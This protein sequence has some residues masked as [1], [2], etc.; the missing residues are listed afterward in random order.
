MS[1]PKH[2]APHP[3]LYIGPKQLE[4]LKR[5][6]EFPFLD[7]AASELIR[8]ADE[9]APNSKFE[10]VRNTHN[11]HLIRARHMQKRMVTLLAA[12]TRTGEETY[13]SAA[14]EHLDEMANWDYWSWIAHRNGEDAPDAI[15]D[16]SYGENS[17]TIAIAYDWLHDSLSDAE[18]RRIVDA[19]R[20]RPLLSGVKHCHPDGAWWFGKRD[21]NWNAV[22][23]GG[24]GMLCLAM[25][26]DA[27]EAFETLK[28]CEESV[29]AFMSYLD[30]TQGGWPE[31]IGYW[32]Y[33]MRYA[34]MFLL[35]H[36]A[37]T[38]EPNP[39]LELDGARRTLEFPLDF[40]PRGQACS[41]GDVNRW[42]PLPF[43]RA[44]AERLENH[45]V[46]AAID[47]RLKD[48]STI[49]GEQR[50]SNAAEW[51][52]LHP[53]RRSEQPRESNRHSIRKYYEGVNWGILADDEIEPNRYLALRSGS[54]AV[55]HGHRDLLSFH[56][57]IDGERL[58]TNASP[59]E[60]L[61]STF[62]PRR[63]ELFEMSPFG[64]NTL[65]INGV[66]IEVGSAVDHTDL[67]DADGAVGFRLD[68]TTAMG[69][70]RGKEPAALFCG[71]LVLLVD[72]DWFLIVDSVKLKHPA[73]FEARF[74]T[75]ERT[76]SLKRQAVINGAEASLRLA[77]AA[78]SSASLT[79]GVSV[80]TT[81]SDRPMTIL[82]W[83]IDDLPT[84][85]ILASALVPDAGRRTRLSLWTTKTTW[86]L[87][88]DIDGGHH[89]FSGDRELR[90]I[91]S[92]SPC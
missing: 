90:G 23:A 85:T 28:R 81:P 63:D 35:S 37:A 66:G 73:R 61:D 49:W 51:L 14:I 87:D 80:P 88:V 78:D 68:A 62:S 27:P 4:R 47:S 74:L 22:C 84:E 21:S 40:C 56:C 7:Q 71:R 2:H 77:F 83:S 3:R 32:N 75:H 59:T 26:E 91:V 79:T 53:G 16:L 58:L 36:E 44:V 57:V 70:S 34:F 10:W 39:L 12:W 50:W 11:A 41:F 82:R 92:G 67:I 25:M 8:E 69:S 33:G 19:A 55:P 72:D 6:P 86:K 15:F 5:R 52:A 46:A 17:A 89:Q 18:R 9:F 1:S 48:D 24:L 43:H 65:F 20:T 54:S 60:Y 29:T 13:R 64:K 38:G 76:R 30:E 42:T 45:R 31:G